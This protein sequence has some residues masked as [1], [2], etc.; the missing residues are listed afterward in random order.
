[1][2]Y[3]IWLYFSIMIETENKRFFWVMSLDH[4]S[5]HIVL[6]HS[7]QLQQSHIVSIFEIKSLC[8]SQNRWTVTGYL[9]L[10]VLL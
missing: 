8:E 3:D 9:S 5:E 10:A 7:D 4:W 2:L 6:C 1:M